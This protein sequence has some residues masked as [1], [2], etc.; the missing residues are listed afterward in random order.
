MPFSSLPSIFRC[1]LRHRSLQSLRICEFPEATRLCAQLFFRIQPAI[2]LQPDILDSVLSW[3]LRP[4]PSGWLFEDRR[5]LRCHQRG[6]SVSYW[7]IYL[8]KIFV[9]KFIIAQNEKLSSSWLRW[10]KMTMMTTST[11]MTTTTTMT[12]M[13]SLSLSIFPCKHPRVGQLR[14]AQQK[15]VILSLS[16]LL[17]RPTQIYLSGEGEVVSQKMRPCY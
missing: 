7:I 2:D 11:M 8:T 3:L 9:Y 13:T 5:H 10:S 15:N 16:S 1:H 14:Q 12:R 6:L 4:I 17:W